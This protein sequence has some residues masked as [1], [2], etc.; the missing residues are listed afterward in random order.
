MT[1]GKIFI[2]SD[3]GE[4]YDMILIEDQCSVEHPAENFIE[5]VAAMSAFFFKL[6][7]SFG[8]LI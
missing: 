4:G 8:I 2:R 7:N 1:S 3:V 5:V 6:G